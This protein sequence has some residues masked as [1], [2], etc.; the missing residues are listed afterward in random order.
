MGESKTRSGNQSHNH[1]A[2]FNVIASLEGVVPEVEGL[3]D[4][5][6]KADQEN[7][8]RTGLKKVLPHFTL[9]CRLQARLAENA[10]GPPNILPL[11]A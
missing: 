8:K 5:G 7:Q 2:V 9:G 4:M 11:P 1:Q 6:A 3:R 10:R